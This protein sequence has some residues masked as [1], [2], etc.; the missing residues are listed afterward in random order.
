MTHLFKGPRSA[1]GSYLKVPATLG[2]LCKA[3]S[4]P[5]RLKTPLKRDPWAVLVCQF[6]RLCAAWRG[7]GPSLNMPAMSGGLWKVIDTFK[8]GPPT[9]SQ[10]LKLAG[11]FKRKHLLTNSKDC[12]LVGVPLLQPRGGGGACRTPLTLQ[13]PS[14]RNPR[15][16]C[17]PW[18]W[19]TAMMWK[20]S[21]P[22]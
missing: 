18:N 13:A 4:V 8:E 12:N 6:Q 17:S 10:P 15:A 2:G 21:L 11:R 5:L 9:G 1:L 19:Q 14:K 22:I 16:A 20:I 7:E 3:S